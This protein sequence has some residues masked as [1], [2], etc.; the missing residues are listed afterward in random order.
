[1]TSLFALF[2]LAVLLRPLSPQNANTQRI[3]A[4]DDPKAAVAACSQ[5]IESGQDGNYKVAAYVSRGNAYDQ[6]GESERAIADYDRALTLDPR[7]A[8]AHRNKG[9]SLTRLGQLG[10]AVQEFAAAIELKP[11][12]AEAYGSRA[13]ILRKMALETSQSERTVLYE[14]SLAD[15]DKTIDLG[16]LGPRGAWAYEGR[17]FAHYYLAHLDAAISDFTKAIGFSPEPRLLMAR[18]IAYADAGDFTRATADVEKASNIVDNVGVAAAS[19]VGL[20]PAALQRVR[21]YAQKRR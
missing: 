10:E 17:G 12:Y 15:Y 6:L 7:N 19:A 18:A 13:E 9:V 3:C 20:T 4:G 11:D 5:L 1:M 2:T 21:D 14:R 16:G 8:F